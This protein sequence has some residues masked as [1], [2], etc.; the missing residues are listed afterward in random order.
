MKSKEQ[1]ETEFMSELHA[2]LEKYNAD[3]TLD[4]QGDACADMIIT[5][6][7]KYDSEGNMISP[8]VTINEGGYIAP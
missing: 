2:L 1:L 7:A 3:F 8:D 4:I 5:L 6:Y